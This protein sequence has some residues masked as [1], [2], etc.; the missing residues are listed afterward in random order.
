MFTCLPTPVRPSENPRLPFLWLGVCAASLTLVCLL[1][2][3][4]PH[5]FTPP[6]TENPPPGQ[7]FQQASI[8]AALRVGL[9]SEVEASGP[10]LRAAAAAWPGNALATKQ[11]S[12]AGDASMPNSGTQSL[13]PILSAP[14]PGSV[15]Q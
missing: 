13:A 8:H 9:I 12:N 14:D 6:R 15:A 7:Y 1:H 4:Q 11:V 3:G 2:S 5:A 10:Y